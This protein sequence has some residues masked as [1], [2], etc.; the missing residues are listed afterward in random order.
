MDDLLE[1]FIY[2]AIGLIGVIASAY[3]NRKKMQQ[4]NVR[5]QVP[6]VPRNLPADPGRDFGPE[7]GPLM[8]LFDIPRQLPKQTEFESVE[9]GPGVEDTGL[10]VDTAESSAELAGMSLE[11]EGILEKDVVS[12]VETFE[13]GQ[14]DIQ[15]LIAKYEAMQ[16]EA[17]QD[18]I[19]DKIAHGEI[20]SADSETGVR[21]GMIEDERFFDPRKAIIYAEILKRREY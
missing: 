10:N 4:R 11:A 9:S 19:G 14:S 16:K 5:Q 13:E 3:R 7:L 17:D 2:I 20:V 18:A 12:E 1:L 21:T 6:Q 15:K 8:E